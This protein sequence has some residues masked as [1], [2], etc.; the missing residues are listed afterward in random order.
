MEN[1]PKQTIE[2]KSEKD[3]IKK[4][5]EKLRED[6]MNLPIKIKGAK[7]YEELIN[8]KEEVKK[9]EEIEIEKK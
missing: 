1:F 6:I 4:T 5:E 2:E 9:P 8:P 3:K 7:G